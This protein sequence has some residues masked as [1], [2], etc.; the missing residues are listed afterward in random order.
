MA[1]TWV[2]MKQLVVC[3]QLV[4]DL[5]RVNGNRNCLSQNF[6]G[7]HS[8]CDDSVQVYLFKFI[9]TLHYGTPSACKWLFHDLVTFYTYRC[10]IHL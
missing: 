4:T 6:R 3:L 2:M 7:F 8:L 10:I 5:N 1:D 9:V